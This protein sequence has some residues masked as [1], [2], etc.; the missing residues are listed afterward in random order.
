LMKPV[1]TKPNSVSSCPFQR[2]VWCF[3]PRRRYDECVY[4]CCPLK[5]KEDEISVFERAANFIYQLEEQQRKLFRKRR[6]SL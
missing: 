1:R 6:F 2:G 3:H 4:T 5:E